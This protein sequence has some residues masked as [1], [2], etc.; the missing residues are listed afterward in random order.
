ML[1][2]FGRSVVPAL[3]LALAASPAFAASF[4]VSGP[5]QANVDTAGFT[6]VTFNVGDTGSITD[7]NVR[8]TIDGSIDGGTAWVTA[9]ELTLI[10]G[11]TQVV[12]FT[13]GGVDSVGTMDATFDDEAGGA[14]PTSGSVI[15]TFTPGTGALSAFD[16]QELSGSW[17]LRIQDISANPGDGDDLAA[18][19]LFGTT[20]VVPEPGTI[21]LF[22]L[23]TLGLGGLV[24]RRRKNAVKTVPQ[25]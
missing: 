1:N 12:F 4:D 7:L 10:H 2:R 19:S 16:G 3:V 9:L 18:W 15:G 23:G 14:F 6:D 11:A 13:T 20:T 22:G 17:T 8:V 21:A 5:P 25:A 24:L